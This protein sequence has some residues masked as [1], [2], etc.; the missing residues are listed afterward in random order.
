[1]NIF[2]IL[3]NARSSSQERT[4]LE[5]IKLQLSKTSDV[6]KRVE[7]ALCAL[8]YV[9]D[10]FRVKSWN[11]TKS[12]GLSKLYDTVI[13]AETLEEQVKA[14]SNKKLVGWGTAWDSEL[15]SYFK[16]LCAG[17]N[18]AAVNLQNKSEKQAN[19]EQIKKENDDIKSLK[20][21]NSRY[22]KN[23]NELQEKITQ[24]NTQAPQYEN[25]LN[26]LNK[27][28]ETMQEKMKKE[29]EVFKQDKLKLNQ[30]KEKLI[31]ELNKM[32]EEKQNNAITKHTIEEFKKEK[33]SYDNNLKT[34]EH[35]KKMVERD[36]ESLN[37]LKKQLEDK[38]KSL[39]SKLNEVNN[40]KLTYEKEKK[41]FENQRNTPFPWDAFVKLVNAN[42]SNDFHLAEQI[43]E[44]LITKLTLGHK[45]E[46]ILNLYK[47]LK[48][49]GNLYKKF[50]IL[51]NFDFISANSEIGKTLNEFF[52]KKFEDIKNLKLQAKTI[53]ERGHVINIE[54]VEILNKYL[55]C[56][57]PN[58]QASTYSK[59]YDIL[60][61]SDSLYVSPNLIKMKSAVGN[62]P[63]SVLDCILKIRN[64]GG[65]RIPSDKLA[66]ILLK[67]KN[68]SEFQ[69]DGVSSIYWDGDS[70]GISDNAVPV[71][72]PGSYLLYSFKLNTVLLLEGKDVE[73]KYEPLET[74]KIFYYGPSLI[75]YEIPL[76][77]LDNKIVKK[78]IIKPST[79]EPN[80]RTLLEIIEANFIRNQNDFEVLRKYLKTNY[81]K[82]NKTC[83]DCLLLIKKYDSMN[84]VL[85]SG[86]KN[87]LKTM[88]KSD[89]IWDDLVYI[90]YSIEYNNN[91]L[92]VVES[93]F[94][95]GR[96]CDT[97]ET[98]EIQVNKPVNSNY[99]DQKLLFEYKGYKIIKTPIRTTLSVDANKD[100]KSNEDITK[101]FGVW[102]GIIRAYSKT[103]KPEHAWQMMT[104]LY[105]N[106]GDTIKND[107]IIENALR[108]FNDT[109]VNE[110]FFSDRVKD[111][112][113]GQL[114]E[115]KYYLFNIYPNISMKMLK[116]YLSVVHYILIGDN[117]SA[118]NTLNKITGNNNNCGTKTIDTLLH[119]AKSI[120]EDLQ[121]WVAFNRNYRGDISLS[122]IDKITD[123]VFS[124]SK[125]KLTPSNQ[126]S[127]VPTYMFLYYP[128][129][130]IF[131][132]LDEGIK[133]DL[134]A[135]GVC[136]IEMLFKCDFAQFSNCMVYNSMI[137]LPNLL[138]AS[139]KNDSLRYLRSLIDP[140]EDT[141]L[142]D[143]A[144]K[145]WNLYTIYQESEANKIKKFA[146]MIR[147]MLNHRFNI[148]HCLHQLKDISEKQ[149]KQDNACSFSVKGQNQLLYDSFITLT[150]RLKNNF[151]S[152][153][154]KTTTENN[155]EN[156]R[157]LILL[158]TLRAFRN[159]ILRFING[160]QGLKLL[161]FD[162]LFKKT[163]NGGIKQVKLF[164]INDRFDETLY[165]NIRSW[166][167]S[168]EIKYNKESYNDQYNVFP[169]I[170]KFLESMLSYIKVLLVSKDQKDETITLNDQDVN[171]YT[172]DD[173][174]KYWNSAIGKTFC[175]AK[176]GKP[177]LN[178]NDIKQGNIG[179][180]WL[181]ATIR[182]M[183]DNG[184]FN[185]ERTF[186]NYRKELK[187]FRDPKTNQQYYTIKENT[188]FITV[189]LY[190]V[191]VSFRFKLKDKK[192]YGTFYT[193]P[194]GKYIDI[195]MN[196][197]YLI[198]G[199][200]SNAW[201]LSSI[202]W[203]CF[204]E[205]GVM[206]GRIQKDLVTCDE[207]GGR[208]YDIEKC[209][210]YDPEKLNWK[211]L[212]CGYNDGIS[213]SILTG[214]NAKGEIRPTNRMFDSNQEMNLLYD[215]IKKKLD[216][217][218][219]LSAGLQYKTDA[220]TPYTKS[221]HS[222]NESIYYLNGE[223]TKIFLAGHEYSISKL[224]TINGQKII[225]LK[226][227]WGQK[228]RD[229]DENISGFDTL[230]MTLEDFYK[231]YSGISKGKV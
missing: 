212:D 194:T 153:L 218:E 19:L 36:R 54:D 178:E 21:E 213:Y 112:N 184:T 145:N 100:K 224:E 170:K 83:G 198:L 73:K 120:L 214:K 75:I 3:F 134:Y 220:D 226:N 144:G 168:N 5:D 114:I 53:I 128:K 197:T 149:N 121:G 92:K 143:C 40:N 85:S 124:K 155:T 126:M 179:D 56:L 34:L 109:T 203:P 33:E 169:I 81:K 215:Y 130:N 61:S 129:G 190:K 57:D 58:K 202:L 225:T 97:Y 173:Q 208:L 46:S 24:L 196:P 127:S 16:N 140:K 229:K 89:I 4:F 52:K 90:L 82:W 23:L 227:P 123:D 104:N 231:R 174:A 22:K 228:Q 162:E 177:S 205:K 43:D 150:S 142:L 115:N 91:N 70:R 152:E 195:M 88:S 29:Q 102:P 39:I 71:E 139:F 86:F 151:K 147:D 180:C 20:C 18:T 166:L 111:K 210:K 84:S 138:I 72:T 41:N 48:T 193:H 133:A 9:R 230:K 68:I 131:N 64:T 13:N 157:T 189:R 204:I 207:S 165:E 141:N 164:S 45:E 154:T 221:G 132:S 181:E 201:N 172:K 187:T 37:L 176:N 110:T 216:S 113:S 63:N 199:D 17:S 137:F 59:C 44:F 119:R 105:Y 122:R 108:K 32:K 11:S 99:Y 30:D 6:S 10:K 211:T 26:Q 191:V 158:D 77:P 146:Y 50:E 67:Y 186:I 25:K 192:F 55:D 31:S 14:L 98:F 101:L 107:K 223:S 167:L 185:F 182:S 160:D 188:T 74:D 117:K 94:G 65:I 87:I 66:G 96:V 156:K 209:W 116:G 136:F 49:A 161:P 47:K 51:S 2:K 200:G 93:S 12:T 183:L 28:I 217:G 125:L 62:K 8:E 206:M 103:L 175:L 38:E 1:M 148:S 42:Y 163:D 15:R 60:Y 76:G 135:L 7:I 78:Q 35:N 95:V 69:Y 118:V 80:A 106:Y 171:I 159:L 222:G 79:S 219:K 27:Q